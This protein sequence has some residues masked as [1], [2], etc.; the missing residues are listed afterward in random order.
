M[1]PAAALFWLSW[2]SLEQDRLL[3]AGRV[4]QRCEQA[5]DLAVNS[6]QQKLSALESHLPDSGPTTGDAVAVVFTE[7]HIDSRPPGRLLYYPV[8]P[9][10]RDS[11]E[12]L[13]AAA[14]AIEFRQ[15]DYVRATAA[16]RELAKSADSAVRAGAYLRLARNL[17]KAGQSQAALVAYRAMVSCGPV[18][19]SSAPA[20]LVA[21]RAQLALLRDL[22]QDADAQRT[23][24][25]LARDLNGR[26]WM[27]DGDT[28]PHFAHE[29]G[30]QPPPEAVALAA[31]VECLWN[32]RRELR[33]GRHIVN[34]GRTPWVILGSGNSA[35]VAG[36]RFVE[37][38]WFAPL[39][40]LLQSQGVSLTRDGTPH[41]SGAQR[42]VDQ[43]AREFASVRNT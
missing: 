6:L 37:Q 21:R 11:A 4:R 30:L 7:D 16:L 31:A 17:C 22:H 9:P 32:E 40:P 38:S 5:A 12:P 20:D 35:L 23:G 27:L 15:Q 25:D 29:I 33:A 36:P 19:V 8:M 43:A 41:A 42:L 2:R 10:N 26:R 3:D 34:Q 13:F 14:E 24:N 28:Y 39:A 1:L 18:V